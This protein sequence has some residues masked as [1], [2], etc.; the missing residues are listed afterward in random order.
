MLM[1]RNSHTTTQRYHG[2]ATADGSWTVTRLVHMS[3]AMGGDAHPCCPLPTEWLA[4]DPRL[5]HLADQVI[6]LGLG[7]AEQAAA[8]AAAVS[9]PACRMHGDACQATHDAGAC[10]CSPCAMWYVPPLVHRSACLTLNTHCA[11]LPPMQGPEAAAKH[12]LDGARRQLAAAEGNHSA[13]GG[14]AAEVEAAFDTF[15]PPI[16]W[17][18]CQGSSASTCPGHT[19]RVRRWAEQ[20]GHHHSLRSLLYP[21]PPGR[22]AARQN[23]LS[24]NT[25]TR[26]AC[27]RAGV[28]HWPTF[29]WPSS[30]SWVGSTSWVQRGCRQHQGWACRPSWLPSCDQPP[31]ETFSSSTAVSKERQDS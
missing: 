17:A 6:Q 7:S 11:A 5:N 9:V 24:G 16:R 3:G 8:A 26:L 28:T 10:C 13:P 4:E 19:T 12:A 25:N 29:C 18:A 20:P 22:R 14:D 23:G 21:G 2:R 15:D 31:G 1:R 27:C 30:L